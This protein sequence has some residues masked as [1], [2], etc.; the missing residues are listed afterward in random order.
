M[1]PP[2]RDTVPLTRTVTVDGRSRSYLVHVPQPLTADRPASAV[3][4]F[5]GA[6]MT[7]HSMVDFSGL[8]ESAD[9]HGFVAVY[10]DGTGSGPLQTFNAGGLAPHLAKHKPDDVRYVV[11]LLND[12]PRVARIDTRRVYATGMSNGGM[13]CYRLAAELSDRI[14]AIAPVSGTMAIREPRPQRAV[15]ILHF[16]GTADRIVPVGGPARRSPSLITFLSLE[17]TLAIW[18]R[19][20]RCHPAPLIEQ[21][22]QAEEDELVVTRKTF[23]PSAPDGAEVVLVEIEGGGHTWP[24]RRPPLWFMGKSTHTVS[25]NQLMWEFFQRHTLPEGW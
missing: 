13:M 1:C 25:A 22:T 23:S 24:G 17:E 19:L 12:L 16:H 18:R 9:E 11:T 3:L 8:N 14:A 5:H 20:N 7:A 2:M 10:A 15:P 4:V 21:L 6:G